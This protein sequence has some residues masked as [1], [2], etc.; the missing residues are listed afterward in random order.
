MP[1]EIGFLD[2]E[3]VEHKALAH[4]E[5]V[6]RG[7]QSDAVTF[8]LERRGDETRRR[9]FAVRTGDSDRAFGQRGLVDAEL[10]EEARDAP[11]TDAVA[12]LVEAEHALSQNL[13]Q[14]A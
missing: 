7:E 13:V 10:P 14:H 9:S 6:G 3:I 2:G 11:E 12:E 4:M 5:Q 8:G 1:F